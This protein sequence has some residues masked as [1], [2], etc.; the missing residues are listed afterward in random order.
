MACEFS[1][2]RLMEY[3]IKLVVSIFNGTTMRHGQVIKGR[4]EHINEPGLS[5]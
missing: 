2:V 1:M 3:L 5:S 4:G